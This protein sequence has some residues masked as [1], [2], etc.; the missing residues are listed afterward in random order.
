MTDKTSPVSVDVGIGLRAN[1][2]V[3]AEIPKEE[4]G[5]LVAALTDIIRPFA[6]RRGLKADQI[7]LQREDVLLE[8][9]KKARLRAE[10]EQIELHPIPTKMLVPFLERASL[11]DFDNTEMQ[12]RWAALLLSAS[13]NYQARHLTFT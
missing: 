2:E 5:R 12:A 4:T 10:L 11:E 1:L 6:E 13:N 8:V 7:R 9:V 3:K